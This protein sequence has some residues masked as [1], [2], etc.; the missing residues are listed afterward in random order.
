MILRARVV[1]PVSQPPIENGAV[2]ISRN[3]IRA[4]G[5]WR[6]LRPHATAKMVD[7]G[8]VIL[9]PGL[10]NAHCHL[11]YTDMAGLLP[12]PKTFTDWIHLMISA[13]AQW[14]YA[15]YAQSWLNGARMLLQTGTTTVAD[16]EVVPELL[17][18]VWDATPL[19]VFSF[20]EMTGIR[21][22]REPR[23]VLREAVEKIESL[24]HP[25]CRAALSPHAPYST[26][27]ELLRFSAREARQRKLPLTTHVAESAQEFEMFIRA[28]GALHAWLKRNE[29][30]MTDCGLGSPVE[31]LARNGILGKNLLAVHA[32]YL[33]PKDAALLAARKTSVVHCPRSHFYFKHRPFPL[34]KLLKAGVNVCL[35]TDS[36]ATVYKTRREKPELNLF[37]EM[38]VFAAAH[39]G[40]SPK[41]I[42]SMATVNGAKALNLAGRIGEL[43]R[44]ACADLV[45]I[46]FAGKFSNAGEVAVNF[47]GH[48]RASM[49][50][51]Q[52]AIG[53]N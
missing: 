11:D 4:V 39:P 27:P 1:L 21:A 32:N 18:E 2:V 33:G 19:R 40:L 43:A 25:R 47:S 45:A 36:L 12:P 23:A 9:L 53:P 50:D 41:K 35:G 17:P 42:L 44:S 46:P 29:R 5:S 13:K 48:V 24:A 22:R 28:S 3:R 16:I 7:L 14:G 20:L 38:R 49:I 26:L 15:E 51:G 37:E 34:G 10:V 8:D 52:W 30:D 31:H 6:Q